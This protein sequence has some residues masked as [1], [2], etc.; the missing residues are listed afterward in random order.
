MYFKWDLDISWDLD[1]V[2]NFYNKF[3]L[4]SWYSS[5]LIQDEIN[6]FGDERTCKSDVKKILFRDQAM[7]FNVRSTVVTAHTTKFPSYK[8]SN[9]L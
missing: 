3:G 9:N 2:R 1:I 7:K 5:G 8:T 6:N 4:C